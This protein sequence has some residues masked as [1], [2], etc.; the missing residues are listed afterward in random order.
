MYVY[1]LFK[2]QIFTCEFLCQNFIKLMF[3]SKLPLLV[4]IPLI[5]YNIK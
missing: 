2:V 3:I 5:I 4:R 1:Y